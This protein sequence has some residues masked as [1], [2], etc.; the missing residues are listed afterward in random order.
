MDTIK[1][2]V[3]A[4]IDGDTFDMTVTHIGKNNKYEYNNK[5]RIR[6]SGFDAPELNTAQGQRDKTKLEK[7]ILNKIVRVRIDARDTYHRVV[8]SVELVQ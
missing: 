2:K 4:V 1:G 8:G 3:I 7:I 5:E 6:L